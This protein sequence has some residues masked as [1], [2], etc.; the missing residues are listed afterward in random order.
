MTG[1]QSDGDGGR[2]RG[3]IRTE[4]GSKEDK[5]GDSDRGR[6]EGGQ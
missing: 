1:H 2:W 6:Q 4:V 3:G 5:K